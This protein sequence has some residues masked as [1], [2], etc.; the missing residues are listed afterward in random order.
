MVDDVFNAAADKLIV[1]LISSQSVI[2]VPEIVRTEVLNVVLHRT[3]DKNKIHFVENRFR[4]LSPM[5]TLRYGDAE[6]WNEFV[7]EQFSRLFLKTM[8]FLVA[9]Y[10]LYWEVEA[11]YSFDE[12]LNRALRRIKPEIVRLKIRRGRVIEV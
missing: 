10:A 7:P 9:C 2:W 1:R 12:K 6:F 11:F 3:L 8:D 4:V 5:V